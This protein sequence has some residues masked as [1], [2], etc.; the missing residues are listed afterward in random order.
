MSSFGFDFKLGVLLALVLLS[1]T[2]IWMLPPF[3]QDP[4]YHSFADQRRILG[5]PNFWNVAS[6]LPLVFLGVTGSVMVALN[7]TPGFLPELK[8]AHLTFFGAV[9]L[10]GLGSAY[11]HLEPDHERLVWDRLP[12]SIL[13]MAFFSAIWG[14]HISVKMGRKMLWPLVTIGLASV[15]YWG[16]SEA[17]GRGDL[18]F[19][20]WVQFTPLLLLPL[21]MLLYPSQLTG[22]GYVWALILVYAGAKAAEIMDRSI[23]QSLGGFSGHE[24]KHWL[25]AAGIFIYY[26]AGLKRKRRYF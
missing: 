17:H 23:Y 24:I 8:L 22:A 19:Y 16:V 6:N 1:L 13:F 26:L 18:R 11:Y 2:V 9:V 12:L 21:I 3:A 5:I 15:I 4:G 25:A 20:A 7:R 10:T 14:E